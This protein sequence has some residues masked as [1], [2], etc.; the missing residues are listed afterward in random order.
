MRSEVIAALKMFVLFWV[1]TPCGLAGGYQHFEGTYFFK[2]NVSEV[3][4][5]CL[6]GCSAV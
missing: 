2:P 6:L 5:G 3:K 4:D 1:V